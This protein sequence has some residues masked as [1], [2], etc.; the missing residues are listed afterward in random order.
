MTL[1][2]H[3]KAIFLSGDTESADVW[4][5]S[6]K[7]SAGVGLGFRT[8]LNEEPRC[9]WPGCIPDNVVCNDQ[10]WAIPGALYRGFHY[11][12]LEIAGAIVDLAF[13]RSCF[14]QEWTGANDVSCLLVTYGPDHYLVAPFNIGFD[15]RLKVDLIENLWHAFPTNNDVFV[16]YFDPAQPWSFL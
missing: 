15:G 10:R 5:W 3:Q 12:A 2:I 13:L 8:R 7:Y 14:A 16:I 4:V 11:N 6:P 1:W 9:K